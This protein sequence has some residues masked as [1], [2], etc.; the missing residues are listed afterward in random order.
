MSLRSKKFV[1][2]I[3]VIKYKEERKEIEIV[4]LEP[5]CS[6]PKKPKKV[7]T[8]ELLDQPTTS[9]VQEGNWLYIIATPA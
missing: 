8:E 3:K 7:V 2:K 6:V 9:V 4:K 1:Q 5:K